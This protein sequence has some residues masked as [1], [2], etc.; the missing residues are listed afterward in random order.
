M[1]THALEYPTNLLPRL[2]YKYIN[3]ELNGCVLIRHVTGNM[4]I[5]G[6]SRLDPNN[7]GII[8]GDLK[9]LSTNLLGH[10]RQ[11]DI[12]IEV[13]NKSFFDLWRESETVSPPIFNTDYLFNNDRK[14]FYFKVQEVLRLTLP[15][16]SGFP[17]SFRVIHT[18]TKCNF[19]HFSIRVFSGEIE[20]RDLEITESQKK[21]I[22]KG[23]KDFLTS[24]AFFDENIEPILL[25]KKC[26]CKHAD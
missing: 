10:F 6:T 1:N 15:K 21:K 7:L 20:I 9:D 17:I 16:I 14:Y 24:K 13:K 4:F 8:S 5:E 2:H 19:W 23:V 11:E 3:E 12:Y 18:P 22:W 26:F 25:P